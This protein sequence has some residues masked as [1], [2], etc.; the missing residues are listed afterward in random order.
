MHFRSGFII[1]VKQFS[2]KFFLVAA[3]KIDF[4][5]YKNNTA[6]LKH[7]YFSPIFNIYNYICSITFLFSSNIHLFL[8][9]IVCDNITVVVNIVK[10]NHDMVKLPDIKKYFT[11]SH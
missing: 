2:E 10:V 7:R 5:N 1:S 9:F 8:S 11:I 4:L 6:Y 3:P